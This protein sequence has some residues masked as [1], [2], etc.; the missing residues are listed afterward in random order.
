MQAAAHAAAEAWGACKCERASQVAA[1][2]LQGQEVM[3]EC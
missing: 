1:K 3:L 2:A